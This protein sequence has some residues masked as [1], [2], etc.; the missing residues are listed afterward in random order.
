[1][2]NSPAYYLVL[3]PSNFEFLGQGSNILPF[4]SLAGSAQATNIPTW[5]YLKG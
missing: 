5:L 4:A 1:M 3:M 2:K